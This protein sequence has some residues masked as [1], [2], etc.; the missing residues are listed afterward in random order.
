VRYALAGTALLVV[1]V[2]I[3]V[4]ASGSHVANLVQPGDRGPSAALF[5]EDFPNLDLPGGTGHDG[6]QFYAVARSP[7]HMD[8][9]AEHLDRPHYR[10]QRPLFPWVAWLLHPSGGGVG[11][12]AAMFAV[13]MAAVVLGALGTG[14]LSVTLGGPAWAGALFPLL[15]GV[16]ASLRIGVGDTLATALVV[17]ALT[18][19]SRGRHRWA[20]VAAVAAV[21]TKE[22]VLLVLA[23]FALWRRDRAGLALAAVPA[24]VAAA[25]AVVVRLVVD[26]GGRQVREV[27]WP[28]AGLADAAG[29]WV[30][31][32]ELWAL[33]ALVVAVGSGA[34]ALV[35]CGLR[36][37]L[38]PAITIHLAVLPL[39]HADVIGLDL[40]ATRTVLPL[41][42]LATV[43]VLTSIPAASSSRTDPLP[44]R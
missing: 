15:P 43:A 17:A 23:G 3:D 22:P 4:R 31:G 28:F 39:F 20:T 11:L 5:H 13:G 32:R 44:A 12:V 10:L 1:A 6:Q 35:R 42:V 37:P 25:W 24:A 36:S 7:M 33:L 38:G 40:N 9:A 2:L 19:S 41:T 27:T 8:E 29:N 18:L 26:A 21:L 34:L 16:Y 14:A 30:D